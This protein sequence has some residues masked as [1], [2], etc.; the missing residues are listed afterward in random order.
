[1]SN[2]VAR[3]KATDIT[4][5]ARRARIYRNIQVQVARELG[6]SRSHV[7]HI[8]SGRRRSRRVE[9]ALAAAVKKIQR[10]AA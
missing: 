9:A 2:A 7:S 5:L 1:M 4:A 8:C 6:V 10:Q 3:N